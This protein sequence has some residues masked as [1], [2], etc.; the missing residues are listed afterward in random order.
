MVLQDGKFYRLIGP[1]VAMPEE[2]SVRRSMAG[3][4]RLTSVLCQRWR[5]RKVISNSF[6]R[7]WEPAVW[8]SAHRDVRRPD[9]RSLHCFPNYLGEVPAEEQMRWEGERRE[10]EKQIALVVL[11]VFSPYNLNSFWTFGKKMLQFNTLWH[12]SMWEIFQNAINKIT[13]FYL[14]TCCQIYLISQITYML[15]FYSL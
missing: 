5:D 9:I 10:W 1:R 7:R 12:Y 15:F 3:H 4:R 8:I 6:A 14:C 13:L 11:R 2:I